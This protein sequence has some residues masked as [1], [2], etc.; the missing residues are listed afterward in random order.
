MPPTLNHQ[1]ILA[2]A[3][4]SAVLAYF[5]APPSMLNRLKSLVSTTTPY[6][7]SPDPQKSTSG[8]ALPLP[9]AKHLEDLRSEIPTACSSCESCEDEG[10]EHDESEFPEL[11][12][13]FDVDLSSEM[14][15]SVSECTSLV[16]ALR[17]AYFRFERWT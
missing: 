12:R 15:G 16:S 10:E 1:H 9:S 13:K 11:P 17:A 4:A 7:E 2:A 5:F 14:L 3:L 6:S 8:P